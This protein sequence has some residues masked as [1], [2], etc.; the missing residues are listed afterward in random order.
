MITPESHEYL[1]LY[2]HYMNGHL[3][4]GGGVYDQPAKY[5]EAMIIIENQGK[6]G[7]K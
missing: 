4:F 3:L 1:R 7:G 6:T 2:R 5:N